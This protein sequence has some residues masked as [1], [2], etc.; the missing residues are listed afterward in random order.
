MEVARRLEDNNIVVNYQALPD[1][2]TFLDS[3]GIRIGVQE[4][5]RFGMVEADFDRLAGYMADCIIRGRRVKEEVAAFRKGFLE[6]RYCLPLDEAVPL[7]ARI[8]A[9]AVPEP[10][11]AARFAE[12][13]SRLA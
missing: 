6:M 10:D 3:S 2:Q 5:T 11:F 12:N 7:A 8:I 4:M 1:D 9:S 13:L